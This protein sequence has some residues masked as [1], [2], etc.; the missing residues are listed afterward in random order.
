M[1]LASGSFLLLA[2]RLADLYGRKLI[3]IISFLISAISSIVIGFSH[4]KYI[5]FV[6][7][8]FQGLAAA[9]AIPA[10][11]GILGAN[12]GP[13]KRKNRVFAAFSAG[14]PVGAGF[15]LVFGGVFTNYISWRWMMWF[16]GI[17]QVIVAVTSWVMLPKDVKKPGPRESIDVWGALL[18][19]AGVGLFCFGLTYDSVLAGIDERDANNTSDSWKT[20]WIILCLVMGVVLCGVFIIVESRVSHPLMPLSIWR[21]PQFGRL[22][23]AFGIG[24]GTFTG[25]IVFGYSLYFLQIDAA[26]PLT[27]PLPIQPTFGLMA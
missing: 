26:S 1:S 18:V 9:G 3:L 2:G 23:L 22:M 24:F 10:A 19:T 6:G 16:F 21:I 12:Y 14:N 7:R 11:V 25:L 17:F 5:F 8:G 20:W 13:G 4:T 15:G 27:V